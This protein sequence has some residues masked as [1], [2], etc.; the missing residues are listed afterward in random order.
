MTHKSIL[1]T[2]GDP[3]GIGIEIALK[4]WMRKGDE[5]LSPFVLIGDATCIENVRNTLCPALEF[6]TIK[7]LEEVAE[8]DKNTLPVLDPDVGASDA[9]KTIAAI[10]M[11]VKLCMDGKAGAV[12]TNPIQKKRLYDADFKYPGHTE[13]LGELTGTPGK[14]TMMLACDELK[15]VLATVHIPLMQVASQ[16]TKDHLKN[17]IQTTFEDLRNKFGIQRPRVVVAGLN[18]HAGEEGSIG[19]EELEVISP[20]IEEFHAKG[21]NIKGPF[22]SD[23]L[24]HKKARENFDAAICMYHDQALIPIKT[25]DFDK[26]VNVTL[27]LPIIRTSPDHGT[28]DDIAGQGIAN[29]TSLIEAVKLAHKMVLRSEKGAS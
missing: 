1:M 26:G 25:I 28:A 24:F 17:V 21:Y 9:E 15:V 3:K 22:P 7:S 8:L 2:M 14:S 23:S 19:R 5:E 12:V 20:V 18:P 4:T 16:L 27:G 29:P 11:A 13:Y 6:A 10:D